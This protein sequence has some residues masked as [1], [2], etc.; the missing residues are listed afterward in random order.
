[1]M[2]RSNLER[3]DA[4]SRLHWNSKGR[5]N[6]RVFLDE[7][8]GQPVGNLWTDIKVINPMSTERLDFDGQKP[9][10]LLQRVL[11]LST[12]PGDIVL[13]AFAGTGT[14]GAVAQKMNR[15]WIMIEM[16]QQCHTHLIPRLRRVIDGEDRGGITESTGWQGGGGFRLFRLAPRS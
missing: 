10:K 4:E 1:M 12:Q 7:Y 9:E 15:R 13:D 14:T 11:Q 6:R 5:P 3:M 16:G 2:S 8:R